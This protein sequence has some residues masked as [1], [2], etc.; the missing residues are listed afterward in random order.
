[1]ARRDHRAK[2]APGQRPGC[3]LARRAAAEVLA[4]DEDR[5]AGPRREQIRAADEPVEEVL[6]HPL[7]VDSRQE[8]RRDDLVRVD[9]GPRNR[10]HGPFNNHAGTGSRAVISLGDARRRRIADAATTAGAARWT[11]PPSPMRPGKLRFE[12]E[13]QRVPG[14]STPIDIPRHGQHDECVQSAPASWKMSCSPS[15][16]AWRRTACEPGVT[17]VG[18]VTLRPRNT[19]A[20]ARRS[21]IRAFVHEPMNA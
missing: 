13:T 10:E 17:I 7:R 21:L 19:S 5:R 18:T 20:A 16:S 2:A 8:A 4:G 9:V 14:A 6:A 11:R 1:E 3:V 12:E 15:R